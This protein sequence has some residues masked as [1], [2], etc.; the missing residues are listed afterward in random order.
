MIDETDRSSS[1]SSGGGYTEK[2]LWIT[3]ITS[4]L[5]SLATI[6]GGGAIAFNVLK[7]QG[8]IQTFGEEE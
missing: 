5:A 4:S 8:K 7:K 2:D 6:I 1:N 3:G